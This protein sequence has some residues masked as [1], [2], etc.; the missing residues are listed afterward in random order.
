MVARYNESLG[1]N[2]IMGRVYALTG[3]NWIDSGAVAT[4][5]G[6]GGAGTARAGME[7]GM[8]SYSLSGFPSIKDLSL[9]SLKYNIMDKVF[10]KAGVTADNFEPDDID[11]FIQGIGVGI[12]DNLTFGFLQSRGFLETA[13]DEYFFVSGKVI[14]DA[15]F[16]AFYID[17]AGGSA[18]AGAYLFAQAEVTAA[19]G[20]LAMAGGVTAPAGVVIEVG[21][22]G[23]LA[24]SAGCGIVAGL[25]TKA[26]IKS[27]GFLQASKRAM[28]NLPANNAG[29]FSDRLRNLVGDPPSSMVNPQAHHVLPQKFKDFFK[30]GIFLRWDLYGYWVKSDPSIQY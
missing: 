19:A 13:Y 18:A 23:S 22:L 21:S 26:A 16:L 28:N 9:E 8:G 14:T 25:A 5:P 30:I 17:L 3:S 29:N 4:L 15:T 6:G 11:Y 27:E 1:I 20:G 12:D 2:E 24:G 10:E 7:E